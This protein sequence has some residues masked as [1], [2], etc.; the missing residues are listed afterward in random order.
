MKIKLAAIVLALIPMTTVA[1][2]GDKYDITTRADEG[3]LLCGKFIVDNAKDP[4]SIKIDDRV[5]YTPGKVIMHNH[6]FVVL[7]GMGRNTYGAVLKHRWGCDEVCKQDKPC[8]IIE[9][10]E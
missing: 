8:E 5:G 7:T 6:L 4:D 10:S 9:F 3:I 2:A 1:H